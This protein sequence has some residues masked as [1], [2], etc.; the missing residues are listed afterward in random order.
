[1]FSTAL[2]VGGIFIGGAIIGGGAVGI[3]CVYRLYKAL[4]G[5]R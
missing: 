3:Y 1:M 5:Y 2:L 4:T